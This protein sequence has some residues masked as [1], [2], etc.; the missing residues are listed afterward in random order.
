MLSMT[1]EAAGWALTVLPI[2]VSRVAISVFWRLSD[3]ISN[4]R[5][6]SIWPRRGADRC[7]PCGPRPTLWPPPEWTSFSF[8]R[9]NRSRRG[10]SGAGLAWLFTLVASFRPSRT[11]FSGAGNICPA[12]S[13]IRRCYQAARTPPYPLV[14]LLFLCGFAA[15]HEFSAPLWLPRAKCRAIACA[16]WSRSA[17]GDSIST[18][19]PASFNTFEVTGPRL[20]AS[21][22]GGFGSLSAR[23]F[24]RWNRWQT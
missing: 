10:G 2:D 1:D 7:G 4:A 21:I 22:P 5:G 16:N 8:P 17:P 6:R 18:A 23:K 14:S 13:P 19:Q 15:L 24:P 3:S 12:A 20:A 11:I 9:R